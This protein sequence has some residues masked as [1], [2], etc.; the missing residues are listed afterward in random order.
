M[1][2]LPYSLCFHQFYLDVSMT[3]EEKDLVLGWLK[4]IG[5]QDYRSIGEVIKMCVDDVEAKIYYLKRA[6]GEL[7]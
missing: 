5:E 6:K 2:L 3:F 1:R 4:S 7:K